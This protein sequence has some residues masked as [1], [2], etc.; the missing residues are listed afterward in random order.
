MESGICEAGLGQGGER[1]QRENQ[2]QFNNHLKQVPQIPFSSAT[3]IKC[4]PCHIISPTRKYKK[5]KIINFHVNVLSSD[6]RRET[7]NF[8][9]CFLLNYT[10]F[11]SVFSPS[12]NSPTHTYNDGRSS[13]PFDQQMIAHPLPA[14]TTVT[15]TIIILV[16]SLNIFSINFIK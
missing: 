7:L 10:H 13:C 5:R 2:F 14:P 15:V 1:E 9:C 3:T 8:H 11:P 12:P 16:W 6:K 4:F